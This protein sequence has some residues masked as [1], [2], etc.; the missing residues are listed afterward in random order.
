VS[1]DSATYA[2]IAR[3]YQAEVID[4]PGDLAAD[5]SVDDAVVKHALS[6]VP[7]DLVV[8]LR[9]TTPFRKASVVRDAIELMQR[10][11]WVPMLRSCHRSSE[12]FTKGCYLGR[13]HEW[14]RIK[15]RGKAYSDKPN[16]ECPATGWYNGYVDICQ[17]DWDESRM[18][19]FETEPVVEIDTEEQ[20][21]F[22]EYLARG[23]AGLGTARQGPAWRGEAGHGKV[24]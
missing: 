9:P 2:G 13:D 15:W 5:G 21:D 1:T 18:Y 14:H 17:G 16:Q 7:A 19:T 11:D 22:A 12:S 20:W 23:E 6:V 24:F 10:L 8:Y 4:R 3:D